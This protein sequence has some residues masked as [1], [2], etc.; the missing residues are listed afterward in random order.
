M[1]NNGRPP[2]YN[3]EF[4]L[5]C[6]ATH[7]V[8][9]IVNR[10]SPPPYCDNTNIENV[11]RLRRTVSSLPRRPHA[12]RSR[13]T[14]TDSN[15][16]R[17]DEPVVNS[18]ASQYTRRTDQIA[19]VNS[20]RRRC[21]SVGRVPCQRFLLSTTGCEGVRCVVNDTVTSEPPL[22][23]PRRLAGEPAGSPVKCSHRFSVYRH[24]DVARRG[25]HMLTCVDVSD[26]GS[27]LVVDS[28]T[29]F[30][31]VF[32][33]LGNH[34]DHA[35]KILGVCGGCFWKEQKLVLATHR[36]LKICQLD[37]SAET[38][39]YTGPVICTKRYKLNFLAVQR[40]CLTIYGGLS[41]KVTKGA[42]ISKVHSRHLFR[43]GKC[44]VEIADV[45]IDNNMFIILDAGRNVI[46]RIDE[47]GTKISK[48]VPNGDI[49]FAA[50]VAVDAHKNIIVCDGSKKQ[51]L[52]FQ[53]S[54]RFVCCLLNF[55][56]RVG[57]VEVDGV[58]LIYGI[59][60][61]YLGQLFVTLSGDGIAEVRMCEI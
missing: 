27:V 7:S 40:H 42:T 51:L 59:T 43:R 56:V 26:N 41:S 53:T 22:P 45:A 39:I 9:P 3:P 57:N 55:S 6:V 46:Y 25:T 5:S 10:L 14:L 50:G 49:H 8:S 17:I 35:F 31:H 2:S 23:P 44:F 38:D 28:H 13:E 29:M 36:G 60:T 19:S 15:L 33:N 47:N 61:N 11:Q 58:P 20:G 34:L 32:S 52:Q 16:S 48:I 12:S 37:G 1:A 4:S 21:N 30:V 24:D 54:G 18:A